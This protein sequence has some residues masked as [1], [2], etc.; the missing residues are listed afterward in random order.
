MNEKIYNQSD[1]EYISDG[2]YI[3]DNTCYYSID[4]YKITFTD[5]VSNT[6]ENQKDSE[7][8]ESRGD[9]NKYITYKCKPEL[10]KIPVVIYNEELLEKYFS[11][12]NQF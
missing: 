11:I 2:E 3:I 9:F 7:L 6:F 1:E 12:K 8:I 5:K 10:G 4:K